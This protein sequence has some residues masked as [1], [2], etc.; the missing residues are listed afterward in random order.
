MQIPH[1]NSDLANKYHLLGANWKLKISQK[2]MIDNTFESR[3]VSQPLIPQIQLAV[4]KL[5][6]TWYF[7][8]HFFKD[9]NVDV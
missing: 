4:K 2:S 1:S 8:T 5:P 3:A 6:S 7:L 9:L